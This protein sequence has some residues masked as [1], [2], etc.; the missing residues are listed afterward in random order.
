MAHLF[1]GDQT[2]LLFAVCP[3]AVRHIRRTTKV[4]ADFGLFDVYSQKVWRA[5]SP[6]LSAQRQSKAAERCH[7]DSPSGLLPRFVYYYRL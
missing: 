2:E 3:A 7:G 1:T 4:T 6:V 5:L